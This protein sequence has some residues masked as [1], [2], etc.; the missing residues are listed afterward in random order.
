MRRPTV[1]G[2]D[3]EGHCGPSGVGLSEERPRAEGTPAGGGGA[4]RAW[5]P[6]G[7]HRRGEGGAEDK[8]RVEPGGE[9]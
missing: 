2:G 1:G 3:G 5:R 8:V 7:H 4:A 6:V 9:E